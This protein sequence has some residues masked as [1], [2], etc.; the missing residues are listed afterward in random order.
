[1]K[2][3]ATILTIGCVIILANGCA[4]SSTVYLSM[5]RE[6][7]VM[8]MTPNI[9]REYRTIKHMR[10]A[11]KA[12]F[13]F[14]VRMFPGEAQPNL[15]EMVTPEFMTAQA[16]AMVNM[17]FRGETSVG[18]VLLPVGVGLI[19]GLAFPPLFI[20]MMFPI[21]EDLKTYSVEG[22]IVKYVGTQQA[23]GSER[24]FD[25]I[26][27]LPLTKPALYIDPMTGLPVEK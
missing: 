26:T 1:M 17:K 11:Q 20:F 7:K 25:P 13:L 2:C 24:K 19:G 12:P 15:D 6:D 3:I 5:S 18:D 10:A 8:S 22:D 21:F 27:G 9:N 14:L 16:D 4:S 23:P